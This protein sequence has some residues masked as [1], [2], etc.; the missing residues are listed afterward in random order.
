MMNCEVRVFA[1][2]KGIRNPWIEWLAR[3]WI[4]TGTIHG[5]VGRARRRL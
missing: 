3:R 4:W 1:V 2:Q 5:L